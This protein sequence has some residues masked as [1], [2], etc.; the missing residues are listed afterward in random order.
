MATKQKEAEEKTEAERREKSFCV[1][2]E[3]KNGGTI[4][5]EVDSPR[6]AIHDYNEQDVDGDIESVKLAEIIEEKVD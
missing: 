5:E 3:D 1:V 2:L 6:E 4:I